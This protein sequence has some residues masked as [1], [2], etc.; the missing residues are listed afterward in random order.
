MLLIIVDIIHVICM[1]LL[2]SQPLE[3][4]GE[5]LDLCLLSNIHFNSENER[6]GGLPVSKIYSNYRMCS[7]CEAERWL[8]T[9]YKARYKII[10]KTFKYRTMLFAS[11]CFF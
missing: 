11:C 2:L 1:Y 7:F 4:Q 5:C 6:L 3:K 10:Y 9:R 8:Y